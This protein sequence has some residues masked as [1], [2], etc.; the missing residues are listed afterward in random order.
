M[1]NSQ[2]STAFFEGF[3]LTAANKYDDLS[4]FTDPVKL[5]RGIQVTDS[6]CRNNVYALQ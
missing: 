4:T 3:T 5:T 2:K 1:A 6:R